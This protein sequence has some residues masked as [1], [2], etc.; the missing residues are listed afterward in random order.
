MKQQAVM[1]KLAEWENGMKNQEEMVAQN[2]GHDI[3]D[4][5]MRRWAEP[6]KKNPLRCP[7][8]GYANRFNIKPGFRWDGVIRGNGF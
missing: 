1:D 2:E 3:W 7:F 8:Q 5:P 6:A 4:D